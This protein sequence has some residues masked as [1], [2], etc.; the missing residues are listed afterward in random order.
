M[1]FCRV[2]SPVCDPLKSRLLSPAWSAPYPLIW[3][4]LLRFHHSCRNHTRERLVRLYIQQMCPALDLCV[5][6]WLWPS[7]NT[8]AGSSSCVCWR[9]QT[10]DLSARRNIQLSGD[11]RKRQRHDEKRARRDLR[12]NI[13]QTAAGFS[14]N[15][16][17][18]C[19]KGHANCR[20]FKLAG[21]HRDGAKVV[22][23][24]KWG[25]D[26]EKTVST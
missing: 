7:V 16:H 20:C 6:Y 17:N 2:L 25:S 14:V 23:G 26:V 10:G 11:E 5:F 8:V 15:L 4:E 12:A 3:P 9:T 13:L 18:P 21:P 1:G 22:L 19:I 24:D